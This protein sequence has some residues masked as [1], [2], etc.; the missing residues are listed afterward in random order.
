AFEYLLSTKI[1]LRFINAMNQAAQELLKLNYQPGIGNR[2]K[3]YVPFHLECP[4]QGC[5][6]TRLEPIIKEQENTSL[7]HI[8][9]TCPKCKE[10]HI[11]E[12]S[13]T[14]PDL[15]NWTQYLSPRVDTRAFLV[16]SF[17]PVILH[18]GGPGETSYHAQVLPA[19]TAVDSVTYIFFRY[20]RIF[21][22]NPWTRRLAAKLQKENLPVLKTGNAQFFQSAIDTNYREENEGV[23]RSLFA[24]C[25]EHIKDTAQQLAEEET[26]IERERANTIRAQRKT[27]DKST[28]NQ[29]QAQIGHLTR[30]RQLLQTYQSQMFGRY[31]PERFGQEAS[32]AW[33]DI[34]M[35][36]DPRQVLTRL[37]NHYQLLTP[38]S[39]IFHLSD[40][41]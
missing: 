8:S 12:V 4:T 7:L 26:R 3:T 41:T 20:T 14:S 31:A 2:P 33:I 15:S 5:N 40:A 11:L 16:Q 23:V 29:L 36:L 28:R 30:Q 19:L 18:V 9:A 27:S 21:Y 38:P 1:R 22:D 39:A 35:S 34:A 10:T 17:T 32:F 37:Q 25:G 24:A 13:A 6:R